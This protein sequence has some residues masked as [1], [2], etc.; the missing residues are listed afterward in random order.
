[1]GWRSTKTSIRNSKVIAHGA[2]VS[3]DR[4]E[5]LTHDDWLENHKQHLKL[6]GWKGHSACRKGETTSSFC[7]ATTH[8]RCSYNNKR[9][10]LR[11]EICGDYAFLVYQSEPFLSHTYTSAAML[12]IN[13]P[14]IR[15]L[16]Q[17]LGARKHNVVAG[18][19]FTRLGQQGGKK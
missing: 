7:T 11:L 1:M 14:K 9:L 15:L 5:L 16:G 13:L 12:R 18:S 10:E 6:Y 19:F 2:I 3:Y 4:R 8:E 17:T